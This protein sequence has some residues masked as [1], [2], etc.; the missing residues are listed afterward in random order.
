MKL[1]RING[2]T[3]KDFVEWLKRE[4]CGC[5]HF[6]ICD[7]EEKEM[8]IVVGWHDYGS[9]EG[10]KICW[11]IGMQSFD[12]A[13]QSDMDIDFDMPYD[14]IT[15]DVYDTLEE[16]CART[17]RQFRYL[18]AEINRVARSVVKYQIAEEGR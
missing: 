1:R 2:K 12:N 8:D 9:G 13:M 4:N 17:V 16:V 18:A 6:R 7:T 5:C 3:L 10:W 15:G 14:R 11:K